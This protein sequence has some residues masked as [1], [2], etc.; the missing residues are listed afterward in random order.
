MVYSVMTKITLLLFIYL[1]PITVNAQSANDM[2]C[3]VAVKHISKILISG[4]VNHL[5]YIKP[6]KDAMK[7]DFS[8]LKS[9]YKGFEFLRLRGISYTEDFYKLV[10]QMKPRERASY[11]KS[12]K[13]RGI[14]VT[15]KRIHKNCKQNI[16]LD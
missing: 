3:D 15:Y 14:N 10:Q 1:L 5:E 11:L 9:D 6:Y 13:A 4:D 7:H 16:V 2:V 12:V 8:L